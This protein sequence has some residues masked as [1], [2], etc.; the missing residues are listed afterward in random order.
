MRERRLTIGIVQVQDVGKGEGVG[1]AERCRMVRVALDLGGPAV[2][3]L[4]QHAVRIAAKGERRSVVERLAGNSVFGRLNVGN[5]LVLREVSAT[6]EPGKGE[7]SPH[8][9]QERPSVDV[10]DRV[11]MRE[12]VVDP[13]RVLGTLGNLLQALPITRVAAFELGSN[14]V[15]FHLI[16]V[17]GIHS[18]L[19]P[20][21][22]WHVQQS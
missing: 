21:Y 5:E 7:R 13:L 9:L 1:R 11:A 19:I 3:A 14:R 18:L 12:L 4:D 17:L 20:A 10:L 6:C 16:R 8:D 15:H 2:E 22:R